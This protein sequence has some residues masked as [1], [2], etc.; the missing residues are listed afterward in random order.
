MHMCDMTPSYLWRDSFP[1]AALEEV[2]DVTYSCMWCDSWGMWRI[3]T[4]DVTHAQVWRDTF[5]C[6]TWLIRM[7]AVT[8]FPQAVLQEVEDVTLFACLKWRIYTCDVTHA[9]L[10][11]DAFMCV[12]WLIFCWSCCK[13]LRT[14]LIP[15]CDVTY[16]CIYRDSFAFATWR[17]RTWD[18]THSYAFKYVTWLIF[19]RPCWNR[20]RMWPI[21]M[22]DMTRSYVGH[23]SI[24]WVTWLICMCDMTRSYMWRDVF[25]TGRAGRGESCHV[26]SGWWWFGAGEQM[27]CHTREGVM[28]HMWRSH[29]THVKESCH[30]CEGVMS[31]MWRSY[32]KDHE[33]SC[34][35]CEG[36]MWKMS[37]RS[38]MIWIQHVRGWFGSWKRHVTH[39]KESCVRCHVVHEW[40]WF[41]AGLYIFDTN[42]SYVYTTDGG[43]RS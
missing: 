6:V 29:V 5:I 2:K 38:W 22:C 13:R 1:H 21:N 34:H 9:Y 12:T 35:T 18:V 15:Q 16:S 43:D 3:H 42:H 36:V 19:H 26:V 24:I 33:R 23:D 27:S 8:H 31:H 10:W 28:L 20:S 37:C 11:R 25:F 7:C 41:G 30:T 4:C 39:V 14:W 17:I 40:W 32:V